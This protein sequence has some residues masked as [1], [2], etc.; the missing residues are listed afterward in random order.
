MK[1]YQSGP[2]VVARL[3]SRSPTPVAISPIPSPAAVATEY[4]GNAGMYGPAPI[5][6][7]TT[8]PTIAA[9]QRQPVV[10]AQSQQPAMLGQAHPAQLA[11]PAPIY[12]ST[13]HTSSMPTNQPY[14]PRFGQNCHSQPV[15][16]AHSGP[17]PTPYGGYTALTP[18]QYTSVPQ[19]PYVPMPLVQYPSNPSQR[20][21][22]VQ[23]SQGGYAMPQVG[24]GRYMPQSGQ[25]MVIQGVLDGGY[26]SQQGGFS[27][28]ARNTRQGQAAT[29][30]QSQP[31]PTIIVRRSG[32]GHTTHRKH[33]HPSHNQ[34]HSKKPKPPKIVDF[35]Y[36]ERA[37]VPMADY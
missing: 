20:I 25:G 5:Q 15:Q 37:A 8:Q 29:I 32:A 36:P 2:P 18:A 33:R 14:D 6:D 7:R 26:V 22:V 34:R 17:G 13:Y 24:Q 11:Q 16:Y 1:Q 30:S 28:Y 27:Q 21:I 35:A 19:R 31:Q 10:A 4:T 12:P 23:G 9:N 3:D